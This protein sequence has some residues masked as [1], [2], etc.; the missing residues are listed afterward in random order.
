[1]T[2]TSDVSTSKFTLSFGNAIAHDRKLSAAHTY[3]G[4]G[5]SSKIIIVNILKLPQTGQEKKIMTI[6]R[7]E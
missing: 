4:A 2:T 6:K 3:G 1:M 7:C 5:V